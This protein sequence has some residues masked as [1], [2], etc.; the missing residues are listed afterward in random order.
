MPPSL[1]APS[2]PKLLWKTN[3]VVQRGF[4]ADGHVVLVVEA[5]HHALGRQVDSYLTAED[6]GQLNGFGKSGYGAD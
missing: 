2:R 6:I 1:A 4:A 3:D 5:Q